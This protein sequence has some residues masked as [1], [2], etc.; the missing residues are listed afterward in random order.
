[1]AKAYGQVFRIKLK[2]FKM[3]KR[4]LKP[5]LRKLK[6]MMMP[7]LRRINKMRLLESTKSLP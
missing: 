7:L 4:K 3:L 2:K 5:M 1:M 6:E